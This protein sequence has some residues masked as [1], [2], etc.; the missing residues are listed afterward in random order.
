ME[1]I[2]KHEEILMDKGDSNVITF[3]YIVSFIAR[4]YNC[5]M[6]LQLFNKTN[7][8]CTF[9]ADVSYIGALRM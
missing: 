2:R 6:Y 8:V 4:V 9:N 5:S 3:H 1:T 7:I